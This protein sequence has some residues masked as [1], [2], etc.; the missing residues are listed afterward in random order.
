MWWN[1]R[2]K[3]FFERHMDWVQAMIGFVGLIAFC[4]MLFV[5]RFTTR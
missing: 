2:K 5:V 3:G 1:K 4:I